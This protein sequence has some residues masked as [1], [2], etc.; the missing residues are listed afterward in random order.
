M[1]PKPDWQGAYDGW[2]FCL[3]QPLADEQRQQV[4]A[5]LA[6]TCIRLGRIDEARQW[7]AKLTDNGQTSMRRLLERKITEQS[8]ATGSA[9][10]NSPAIVAPDAVAK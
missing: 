7:L 4:Y 2:Q 3:K 5:N 6:R 8:T 9:Q 1:M 10:T